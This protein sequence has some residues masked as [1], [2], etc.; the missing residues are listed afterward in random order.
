VQRG[1]ATAIVFPKQKIP[2]AR[3]VLR[4]FALCL[5]LSFF[6]FGCQREH[7]ER[8]TSA[9]IHQV[10]QELA[11]AA[12]DAEPN[13]TVI[14]IRHSRGGNPP[15]EL[16]IQLHGDTQAADRVR[17]SLNAVA[18]RNR[19]T[20]DAETANGDSSRIILRSA[21]VPTHR[22]EIVAQSAQ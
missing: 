8:L 19:L 15:D 22:I 17:Q 11:K 5:F 10:T 21:G 12:S 2:A 18:T 13:R 4:F 6:A 9:K 7:S 20:V 16:R 14:R 3:E 1:G